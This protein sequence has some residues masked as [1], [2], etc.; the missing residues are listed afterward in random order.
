MP[1]GLRDVFIDELADTSALT[2][3]S[4]SLLTSPAV[5]DLIQ[6]AV[7]I[8]A[9]CKGRVDL[10]ALM[11]HARTVVNRIDAR[12]AKLREQLVPRVKAAIADRR[13]Q[14]STDMWTDDQQKRHFI[15]ITLS[16]T[17]E[18]GTASETYDLDVAQFP[19]SRIEYPK[20]RAAILNTP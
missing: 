1:G 11:P 8:G 6:T 20:W 13:C 5:V 19:S 14:G 17:N 15:A 7:D 4:I 9:R 2:M 3:G 10:R 12:A 16:F 18:Q